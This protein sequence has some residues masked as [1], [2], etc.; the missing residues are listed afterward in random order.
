MEE[1]KKELN[2]KVILV[3]VCT[4]AENEIEDSLDELEQLVD[5]AGASV[6]ARVVQN[7]ESIHPGTYVGKGKIE[8]IRELLF[9]TE[10]T[11]IVCDDELSPAQMGH[12][13]ELLDT[14]VMDR[15]LVILDIFARRA[16]TREGKIQVEL[17]QL[18]YRAT[19][20]TGQGT[21]LSRLGG[22]IGTRGPGEKKLEM[23]RRLIRTRISH[24]KKELNGV[25]A[26]RE[27]QR[28]QRIRTHMP[29][30]CI[31]GY[32]NAG[33]STLLNYY[34]NAGVLEENQLFATLDPT[35][36]SVVLESGQTILMTDTVG[37]IQKLP[38]HLIDAFKSTLEEAVYSDI[39]LHVV[40]A[41]NPQMEKQMEAVY[42][43]LHQLG[44]KEQPI[45]TAFNKMDALS[46]DIILKDLHAQKTVRISGKYGD[47]TKELLDLVEQTLQEQKIY[48]EKV[49]PY[50]EAGKIQAIR[51]H[52]QLV[53][54][55]Y[56]EDGIYVEAYVPAEIL[57]M[58]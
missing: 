52:G 53:K 14:K 47:G 5:T 12:L 15:T 46:D 19:R 28:K 24:L 27:V 26:H 31:V 7:R 25:I 8:E 1:I 57:G 4:D 37:F 18:R 6:V 11:G 48:V 22:G 3:A 30:V 32:T 56:R 35:T 44:V 17:A 2:E 34:T 54:E 55:E 50:E 42:E 21:S 45:I 40:D 13:E 51:N 9:E 16:Y 23:D 41:A 33:K 49:Y 20:L 39:I 29:V 58:V 36:K 10:A 38:H 43:T